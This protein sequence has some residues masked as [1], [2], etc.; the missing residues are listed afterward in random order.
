MSRAS[1]RRALVDYFSPPAING[2]VKVY[3]A[4]PTL[5]PG[6]DFEYGDANWAAIAYVHLPHKAETRIALGG[7]HGGQKMAVWDTALVVVYRWLI[8]NP[9]PVDQDR[10]A[11]VDPLDL[12]L[13]DITDLIRADRTLGTGAGGIAWQAGEGDRTN[14]PDIVI[15]ADLPLED[16]GTVHQWQA[17][18]FAV[19]EMIP[20]G[21]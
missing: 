13:D 8:P 20:Q 14:S 10:A 16:K 11:W 3:R 2:L 15:D 17:V 9:L 1:V 5:A 6:Q 19:V 21:A 7:E 18:K 4:A 12:L